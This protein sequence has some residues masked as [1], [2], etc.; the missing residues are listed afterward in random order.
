M[1]GTVAMAAGVWAATG[2]A[3][4][5]IRNVTDRRFRRELKKD[6][7]DV[8]KRKNLKNRTMQHVIAETSSVIGSSIEGPITLVRCLV[9]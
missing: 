1:L 3:G 9:K 8:Y 5:K 6:F 2:V 7:K 4:A